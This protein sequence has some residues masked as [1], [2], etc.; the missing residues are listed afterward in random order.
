MVKPVEDMSEDEKVE[1]AFRQAALK[2]VQKARETD[3]PVILWEDGKVKR[4]HPD[5]IELPFD[6]EE[7]DDSESG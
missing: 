1:A 5:E 7:T 6:E 4:V 2:V 3:T